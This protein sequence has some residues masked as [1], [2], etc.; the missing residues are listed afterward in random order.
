VHRLWAD[1]AGDVHA[2]F[3]RTEALDV[4]D[5]EAAVALLS[6][7][8]RERCARFGFA[9]DRREYAV[10]H[11][12]VRVVVGAILGVPAGDVQLTAD[13][14]GRPLV[15]RSDSRHHPPAFSLSHCHEV[16]AC[17]VAPEGAVGIDVETMDAAVDLRRVALEYFTPAE[18]EGLEQCDAEARLHRFYA[19]WTLKEAL[20]KATGL[21]P[22][23]LGCASFTFNDGGA[24]SLTPSSVLPS[25]AWSVGVLDISPCCKLAIVA[26][27]PPGSS[28]PRVLHEFDA[29]AFLEAAGYNGSRTDRPVTIG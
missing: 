13:E 9:R 27:E 6:E 21:A 17:V 25:H 19:L 20:F 7:A 15:A 26:S 22:G 23:Q 3:C 28:R 12:L 5:L 1:G 16:V 18:R 11:A 4:T 14:R 8:E 2:F 24:V 10:A 29:A